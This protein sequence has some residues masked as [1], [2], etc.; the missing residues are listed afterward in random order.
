MSRGRPRTRLR[1]VE[2]SKLAGVIGTMIETQFGGNATAAAK[3]IG[4]E[5]SLL[6]R[7]RNGKL[8]SVRE[9]DLV[10]LKRALSRGQFA[11]IEECIVDP[12]IAELLK[13]FDRWKAD[14][15]ARFLHRDTAP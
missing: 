6:S 12:A 14:E 10:A 4:V 5:R 13:A 7:V 2:P 8:Q 1:V 15:H 9:R 11:L 3:G